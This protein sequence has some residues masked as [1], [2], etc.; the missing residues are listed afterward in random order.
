MTLTFTQLKTIR[1]FCAGLTSDPDWREVAQRLE[2]ND[3]DFEVDGVRFINTDYIDRIQQDELSSD[4]YCLG[5][6][7]ASFVASVTGIDQDVI[8]AMQKAEAYEAVGKL[9]ISLDKLGEL[10][11]ECASADGYGHYFNSYDSSEQ[12]LRVG[13]E[14]FHVFDNRR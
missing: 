14:L 8:E 10:Q 5:C 4:L 6:F 11:E 12:E 2:A 9:I 3:A 13:A 1:E 7:N